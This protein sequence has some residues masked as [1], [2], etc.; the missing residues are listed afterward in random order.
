MYIIQE[1]QTNGGVSALTPAITKDDKNQA[2]STFFTTCAA[3]VIS[4][5]EVHTVTL[6]DE[7]GQQVRPA[8]YFE[9][10]QGE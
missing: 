3:A 6:T 7:H 5:V 8:E 4:N 9:H 1:I 10:P 2:L